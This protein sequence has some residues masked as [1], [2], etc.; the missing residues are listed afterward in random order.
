MNF[1]RFNAPFKLL[2]AA[3]KTF[4]RALC[5]VVK[6][7]NG[8]INPKLLELKGVKQFKQVVHGYIGLGSL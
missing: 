7:T 6:A 1:A 3:F 2:F 8:E 4:K 5:E